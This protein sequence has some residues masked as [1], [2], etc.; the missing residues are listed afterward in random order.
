MDGVRV[1]SGYAPPSAV[2]RMVVNREASGYG[3]HYLF[4]RT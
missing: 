4:L 3:K 2:Q 1:K